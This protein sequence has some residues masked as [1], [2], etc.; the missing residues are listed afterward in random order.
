MSSLKTKIAKQLDHLPDNTLKQVSDFIDFLAWR[1][2]TNAELNQTSSEE[3]KQ[4]IPIEI[5][6]DHSE[7]Q[8]YKVGTALVV[9]SI[10]I[11]N[12]EN[13]VDKMRE[14]RIN[15]IIANDESSV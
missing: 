13:S 4:G 9:K 10:P 11:D 7:P 5:D 2:S 12:I 3:L 14:E 6:T 15:Q 8:V 1:S